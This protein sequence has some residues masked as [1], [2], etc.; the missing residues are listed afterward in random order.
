VT[1]DL[2]RRA[3]RLGRLLVL[4]ALA[5]AA[6]SASA[7]R[8]IEVYR[9]RHRPAAELLPVAQVALADEGVVALDA[10]TNALVLAGP[11]QAVARTLELL[12]LQDRARAV[13]VLHWT[14]RSNDE[15]EAAGVRI[16]WS[17][18]AGDVRV[19]TPRFP[20]DEGVRI[21]VL[22]RQEEGEGSFAGTLRLLDGEEGEI[23]TGE[24]APL[25]VPHRRGADVV[26]QSAESGFRARP[27][28]L[29]D[30]RVRVE[31]M[32]EQSSLEPGGRVAFTGAAT[33][34]TLEPGETV[35]LAG[36]D[37]SQSSTSR[38]VPEATASR[39]SS[40]SRVLL[41]RAEVETPSP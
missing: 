3:L 21:G 32:P 24:T 29:G 12:R 38:G 37:A 41:L 14:S 25:V 18:E 13:V 31:I 11:P 23:G 36:V 6:A 35:A 20:G 34:V 17:I 1:R 8:S 16:D 22:G 15:L 2:A 40:R 10:G 39:R 5:L 33:S 9:P 27:R 19:G 7:E 4:A 28:V 26:L 30:G